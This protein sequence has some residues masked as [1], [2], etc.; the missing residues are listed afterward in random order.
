MSAPTEPK[1]FTAQDLARA[2][3]CSSKTI[4][5]RAGREKWSFQF[6]GNRIVYTPPEG[7]L[8]RLPADL[9]GFQPSPPDRI[10]KRARLQFLQ[11][12]FRFEALCDLERLVAEGGSIEAALDEVV[13]AFQF[14][15]SKSSLRR[16][17]KDFLSKGFAGLFEQKRGRPL[18]NDRVAE[19]GPNA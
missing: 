4:H 2:L 3:C 8:A 9:T 12:S 10:A 6:F 13:S 11:A 15:I 16:W 18:K 17:Q 5:R 1:Y 7:I 14:E 19:G